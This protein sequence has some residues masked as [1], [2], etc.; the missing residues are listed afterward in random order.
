MNK[1][2]NISWSSSSRTDVGMVRDINEDAYLDRPDMG[3]WA[4]ADGMGGHTA[5]D[6]ASGMICEALNA[7]EPPQSLSGFVDEVES[8]LLRVND[9]LRAIAKG[10]ESQTIGST[11]AAL[12]ARGRHA[13]CIWAGDSRIYR[14]RA[15]QIVQITQ[16]HALVEELVEKGILTR[17]QASTHPQGNLVTRAIGATDA[18][19]LDLEIVELQPGDIFVICS[20]GLD[21]ELK[22]TEILQIAQRQ[23]DRSL[24]DTLV[25]LALSRGS[26]DNVTVVTVHIAGNDT[27]GARLAYGSD[28]FHS[29]ETIPR[30]DTVKQPTK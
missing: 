21:K 3:F 2:A 30:F 19:K 10:N 8:Q 25:D 12:V 23:N 6:V 15:G 24:S 1:Q 9:K 22:P 20:D 26:R 7:L 16:D 13:I 11:V 27:T 28:D 4:V 14:C 5:G 18:L 17:L 29:A